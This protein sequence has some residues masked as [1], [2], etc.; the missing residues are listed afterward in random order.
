MDHWPNFPLITRIGIINATTQTNNQCRAVGH[1]TYYYEVAV[2]F[3]EDV[4]LDENKFIID[5][6]LIDDA[7][8]QVQIDSCE[9][10]SKTIL[11]NVQALL[12]GKGIG[13]IGILLRLRH[14]ETLPLDGPYFR[15]AR[16]E[17]KDL[18]LVLSLL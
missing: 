14:N 5:H 8:Q 12:C 13:Y 6:Q 17:R 18:A 10:M 11:D 3:K 1:K 9:V 16:C 7:V 2:L 4:T 15:Q